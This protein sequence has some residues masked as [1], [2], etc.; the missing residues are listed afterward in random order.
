MCTQQRLRSV[1]A[2]PQS[3]QSL[4]SAWRNFGS[5]ELPIERIAKTDQTGQMPRLIWVFGGRICHFVGF[6]GLWLICESVI[7]AKKEQNLQTVMY[8]QQRLGS[9][10]TPLQSDQSSLY[11][12]LGYPQ[13]AKLTDQTAL[14]AGL[15]ESWLGACPVRVISILQRCIFWQ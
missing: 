10:Y 6:V 9:A 1:W 5:F 7:W 14:R 2:S 13:S 12:V 8:N 4:L 11:T 15:S 3:D